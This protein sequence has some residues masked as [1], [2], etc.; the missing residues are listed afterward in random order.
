[1][2]FFTFLASKF[3]Y[4]PSYELYNFYK[5]IKVKSYTYNWCFYF[6]GIFSET[7]KKNDINIGKLLSFIDIF[8]FSENVRIV[9][10]R[11]AS[12]SPLVISNP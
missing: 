9:K 8:K 12:S 10:I 2:Q 3:F 7:I 4:Y 11:A 5:F 6:F 1:M